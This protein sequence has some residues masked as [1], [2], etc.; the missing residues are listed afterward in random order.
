M[1]LR[2]TVSNLAWA[3]STRSLS[4]LAWTPFEPLSPNLVW[5]TVPHD[6]IKESSGIAVLIEETYDRKEERMYGK[7]YYHHDEGLQSKMYQFS[8][9]VRIGTKPTRTSRQVREI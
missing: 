7:E 2:A 3:C 1:T 5:S 6:L 4:S 9:Q 8:T